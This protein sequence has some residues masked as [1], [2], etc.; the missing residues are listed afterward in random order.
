MRVAI[1]LMAVRNK[2]DLMSS[3]SGVS[4]RNVGMLLQLSWS[5]LMGLSKESFK[6]I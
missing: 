5:L 4:Y 3:F 1:R 6:S 2:D